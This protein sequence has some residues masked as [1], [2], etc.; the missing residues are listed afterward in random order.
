MIRINLLGVERV[1]AKKAFAV[2]IGQQV[3]MASAAVLVVAVLG[4]GWWYWSLRQE[5]QQVDRDIASAQQEQTRLRALLAEVAQFETQ[6]QELQ[7]R[8]ALIRQL[9]SGQSVPVQLLD[10]VSRSVPDQLWLTSLVQDGQAI[11]I[12]GRST[13]LIA[14]S[15]FVGNL[16][17]T[18]FLQKASDVGQFHDHADAPGQRPRVR[19]DFVGSGGDVISA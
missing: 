6:R 16:G 5:S 4:I 19:D 2:D 9:R 3:M 18:D 14:L 1:R 12:D 17:D 7:Q 11:T 13:T 8:V 15:D 10:H